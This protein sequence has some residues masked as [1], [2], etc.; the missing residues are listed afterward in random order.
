M[1]VHN[2]LPILAEESANKPEQKKQENK[3]AQSKKTESKKTDDS[4][5]T[6]TLTSEIEKA[7]KAIENTLS[8]LSSSVSEHLSSS[9]G[10]DVSS[11]VDA[12]ETENRA[13]RELLG[14]LTIKVES[15]ESRL[16]KAEGG[17]SQPAPAKEEQKK[18][19]KDD[20]DDDD[21]DLFGSDEEEDEETEEEKKA[22]EEKLAA[23]HAKKATKTAV[24]AKS[25]VSLNVK[26]WDDET[27]LA[28][29]ETNVRS[30][31]MDGLV[32]G[33]SKL[34]PVAY[35]VK[36]LQILCVIEDAKVSTEVLSEQIQEFED[37]V[38]SVDIAAFNKI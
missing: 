27:D 30:I 35:G 21:L 8:G 26:P 3:K 34:V 23:Y 32:W 28:E 22:R 33:G 1:F 14:K 24:I 18:A 12:L 25:S 38:Q 4:S 11:R 7:R 31:E 16:A 17:A 15:L 36:M 10:M 5:E 9:D 29:M 2:N 20:D 13:L 19:A 6:S 37:V